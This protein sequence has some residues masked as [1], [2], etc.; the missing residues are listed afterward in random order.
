[1]S[2]CHVAAPHSF[3]KAKIFHINQRKKANLDFLFYIK[4]FRWLRFNPLELIWLK[5][6]KRSQI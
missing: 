6:H 3:S 4:C 2:K 1:M 5:I